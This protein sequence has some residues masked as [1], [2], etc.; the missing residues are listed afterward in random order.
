[1]TKYRKGARAGESSKD[2]SNLQNGS[3]T[4]L[5]HT[6]TLAPTQ[7]RSAIS[8]PIHDVAV[9]FLLNEYIQGSQFEYLPCLYRV[10]DAT[11][12]LSSTLKAVGLASLSLY[13]SQPELRG[14][15][16]KFYS[17]AITEVNCALQS[18][19]TAQRD[20]VLASIMLLSLY[21][22]LTLR[23]TTDTEAW[24][25]HVHGAMSLVALRG[26]EQFRSK[27]GLELFK[28]TATGIKLFCI[29]HCLRIPIQLREMLEFVA[30]HSS[31]T[32]V[33]LLQPSIT[34][35]FTDLRADIAEGLLSEPDDIIA[36]CE[37]VLELIEE[38]FVGLLPC[39]KYD[40]VVTGA[41]LVDGRQSF[42]LELRD[43]HLVQM[44][45]TALMAKL[46]L[47]TM[48]YE[49]ALRVLQQPE[50]SH[51]K[52]TS[53]P[54]TKA[55]RALKAQE[56]VTEAAERICATIPQVLLAEISQQVSGRPRATVSMG[57]SLIWPLF[58]VGSN[59]L[60]TSSTRDYVVSK[61]EYIA[62]EFKL[63]QARWAGEMLTGGASDESWMHI[64]HTF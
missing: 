51:Q 30:C 19:D 48:I 9:T 35:A 49:Q 34:E 22:A 5:Q 20:D 3:Y 62:S 45:N 59:P 47:N 28:Q 8:E 14:Q 15:A 10:C 41:P 23:Q 6:G 61:L 56:E 37:V 33:A 2:Q 24:S 21:E 38:F 4:W 42:H 43:H 54:S 18:R 46:K 13:T 36:R 63:P 27:L 39:Q 58:T 17:E 44:W 11:S 32:D 55:V 31:P 7:I 1:M 26:R 29:Q 12:V 50:M 60:V 16:L 57:Y 53:T 40:K 25:T 64:Y 52:A